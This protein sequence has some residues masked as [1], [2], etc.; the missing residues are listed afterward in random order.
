MPGGSYC[1]G[2]IF[3]CL[4]GVLYVRWNILCLSR[5][6]EDP[7]WLAGLKKVIPTFPLLPLSWGI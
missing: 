4:D 6:G 1:Q 5:P 2:I 3:H 7:G